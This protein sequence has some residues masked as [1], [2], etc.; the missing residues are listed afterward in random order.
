M[1]PAVGAQYKAAWALKAIT[2]DNPQPTAAPAFK[3]GWDRSPITKDMAV[4]TRTTI[5]IAGILM[6]LAADWEDATILL[7][8]TPETHTS[9]LQSAP[10]TNP[11]GQ[12]PR[13][14]TLNSPQESP[15]PM[16]PPQNSH[17]ALENTT[18][19]PTWTIT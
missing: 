1:D 7:P 14:K 19:R 4:P 5:H 9:A 8:L 17:S 15:T 10:R 12:E 16:S 2:C 3:A 13:L 6:P 18:V 11:T